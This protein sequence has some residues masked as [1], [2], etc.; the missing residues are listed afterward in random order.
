MSDP[1]VYRRQRQAMVEMQLESRGIRAPKVLAAFR[2]VPRHEF[3]V[4]GDEPVAYQD[5][6]LP[7][8]WGQTISQPFMVAY[9]L[10]MLAVEPHHQVLEVGAGSGYQAALLG[11]IAS[12]VYSIEIVGELALRAEATVSRLGYAN[13]YIVQGDGSLGYAA[14]A[15]YDR[16]VV[17]AGAPAIPEPLVSQLVE[18]GRLVIPLGDR[19]LQ[20]CMVGVKR[21]GELVVER[22]IGCVFVPLVG[23]KGWR[24]A[25]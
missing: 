20:T 22:G 21:E 12:E 18:G 10:E 11:Q 25:C 15:P 23:E 13:V 14:Q 4:P 7:I 3:V 5:R 17:A 2:S 8:G 9:M 6:A 1:L 16:I 24:A 19:G